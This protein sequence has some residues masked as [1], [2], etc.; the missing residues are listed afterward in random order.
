MFVNVIDMDVKKVKTKTSHFADMKMIYRN[1]LSQWQISNLLEIHL[2]FMY[3]FA[4]IKMIYRNSLPQWQISNLFD[5]CLY[6]MDN[7]ANIKL[8]YR[9]SYRNEQSSI[10]L[11]F[12]FVLWQN[13]HLWIYICNIMSQNSS[14]F[15]DETDV[16]KWEVLDWFYYSLYRF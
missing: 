1:S 13:H 8:I 10:S 16:L 6:S 14:S 5:V 2:Y 11:K 12:I 4:N 15:E 9:I 3:H 7:F